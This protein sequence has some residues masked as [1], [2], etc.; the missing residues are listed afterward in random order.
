M[1]EEMLYL[2]AR[3]YYE[4]RKTQE[5]IS[6]E[7]EVSRSTVSRL[8]QE[9]VQKNI[10][11]IKLNFPWQ[12]DQELERRLVERFSLTEARVLDDRGKDNE[13]VMRGVGALAARI[14]EDHLT[15]GD[16]VGVSYG[17]AVASVVAALAPHRQIRV[18]AV[19]LLGA[20]GVENTLIDGTEL[21][22]KLAFAFGGDYRYIPAPLLV[23]DARTRNGLIQLPQIAETLMM[24]RRARWTLVGVGA[25]ASAG[26]IWSGYIDRKGFER[27]RA[28]GAVGHM[29]GQFFDAQG[30]LLADWINGKTIGI[31]LKSL[32]NNKGVIAVASGSEK[33]AA[34]LG[35]LRGKYIGNLVT[36][37]STANVILSSA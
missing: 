29:C 8:L 18:T 16:I 14:F 32:A 17:R 19:P 12:R 28:Q 5:E 3:Q 34:I 35:A 22:R 4:E 33:A 37:L 6:R 11:T 2:V 31:G 9:A 30:R 24:A 15:D 26:L 10:V 13:T 20:L 23:K 7:I 36:D 25:T 1:N 27:L 21:V